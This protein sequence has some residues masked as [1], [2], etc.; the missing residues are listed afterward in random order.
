VV[1]VIASD[2]HE[3][4]SHR[5]HWFAPFDLQETVRSRAVSFFHAPESRGSPPCFTL[6]VIDLAKIEHML[7]CNTTAADSVVFN[8]APVAVLFAVFLSSS[9]L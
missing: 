7:L 3:R 1:A 8:D 4:E 9:H 5:D 2:L 6:A